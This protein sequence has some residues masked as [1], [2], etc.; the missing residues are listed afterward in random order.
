MG[1]NGSKQ[2]TFFLH[3]SRVNI[4]VKYGQK[5]KVSP[6]VVITEPTTISSEGYSVVKELKAN[7]SPVTVVKSSQ[8][9]LSPPKHF[10]R[11]RG[12]TF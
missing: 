12:K 1:C 8:D 9:L 10:A 7:E 6:A 4:Q 2:K 3:Q 5:R 11:R